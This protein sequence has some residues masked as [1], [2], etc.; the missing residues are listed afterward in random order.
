MKFILILFTFLS[1]ANEAIGQ[2]IRF[3]YINKITTMCVC[4]LSDKHE[5]IKHE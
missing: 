3:K 4:E 2:N 5:T 1:C